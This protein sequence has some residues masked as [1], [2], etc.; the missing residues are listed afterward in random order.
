MIRLLGTASSAS[1]PTFSSRSASCGRVRRTFFAVVSSVIAISLSAASAQA[2]PINYGDFTANTVIYQMV[3][4]AANSAGDTA[5]LFGAPTVSGDSLDF[6]PV[7]F[8]A[9]VVGA[10]VDITDGNLAF[11]VKA[12]PGNAINNLL[13]QERGDTTLAGFGSD[14]TFSAVMMRGVLNI[15]EVDFVGINTISF[16]ISISNFSP[17]GGTYGLGT[18]GGGGPLYASGWSGSVLVDLTTAN[19]IVANALASQG[20]VPQLGV[21]K[22]S[23]NFNN[24]LIAIGQTGTSATIAKKDNGI[25]ITTN[26]PE[27]TSCLMAVFGL[28]LCGVAARRG[29]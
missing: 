29:R 16:P 1:G 10:G 25:I 28:A 3:R 17:S 12:K 11:M 18:D 21:T 22:I 20:V 6:D 4:E 24:T 7:G 19:P 14:T 5:P 9:S 15:S 23:V 2:A 13:I 26:I 27:P 8:S